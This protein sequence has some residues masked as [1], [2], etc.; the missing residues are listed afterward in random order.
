MGNFKNNM[1]VPSKWTGQDRKYAESV[2]E[3]VDILCGNRGDPLDRAITARDLIDSGIARLPAGANFYSGAS[4]GLYPTSDT[5]PDLT[6]PPT[7]TNLTANGAFQNILIGW[8]LLSYASH[9]HIEIYRHTSDDISSAELI[10]VTSQ[11]AGVYADNV[12]SDATF[13]YWIRAVNKNGDKGAFNSSAGTLGQTEKDV[14][15]LMTSL[16]ESVTSS[17][18]ATFLASP[19]G[20]NIG[21]IPD[22]DGNGA[23]NVGDMVKLL[24]N[25][26]GLGQR[27]LFYTC[28]QAVVAPPATG[29]G[30]DSPP[31]VDTTNAYWDLI[32]D[33]KV[34]KSVKDTANAA[35][36]SITEINNVTGTSTSAAATAIKQAT[37]RINDVDGNSTGV[38]LEQRMGV[39]ATT[40]GTL[41]G[42]FT[43][44]IN[45]T[46]GTNRYVS[47]FGLASEN[48]DGTNSSAF[49]IAA[50]RFAIV[51]PAT[52]NGNLTT[53]PSSSIIPFFIDSGTT[54]IKAAVIKD[55]SIEAAKIGSLNADVI[56]AGEIGAAY[57]GVGSIDASKL[58]IDGSSITSV[59][60]NGVPTLQ[61][62][63]VSANKIDSGTLNASNITVTNL[64][65]AQISGDV[66][67]FSLV[68]D[69]FTSVT[70]GNGFTEQFTVDLLPNSTSGISHKPSC[71]VSFT[72]VQESDTAHIKLEYKLINNSTGADVTTYTE[73]K[74][75]RSFGGSVSGS[76]ELYSIAG[77]VNTATTHKT[78]FRVS[79]KM[80]NDNDNGSTSGSASGSGVMTGFVAGFV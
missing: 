11:Q 21:N 39:Q 47:G 25:T 48:V 44:K 43:V 80:F 33:G 27:Y 56:N 54:Y 12:G 57:I 2:K 18:L 16:S 75:L 53:T 22:W 29:H 51:D 60:V 1:S 45:Q 37:A 42:Q 70:N 20:N 63:N 67:T 61:L 24:Y 64:T 14:D 34:L 65:A 71:N 23:Y 46:A 41:S 50:D 17:K 49:I 76:K 68:E 5:L 32:G 35:A 26:D 8:D 77:G 7:P 40:N 15:A 59:V 79:V 9:D 38:T 72:I 28:T 74:T 6:I 66:N 69:D 30:N 58:N 3:N 62:G 36:A 19:V 31:T 52:Y 4:D 73:I 10:A 78:R 13:Y 55:A